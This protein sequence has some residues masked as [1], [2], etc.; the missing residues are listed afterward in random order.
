MVVRDSSRGTAT[1]APPRMLRRASAATSRYPAAG[2]MGRDCI[3]H[4]S[5]APAVCTDF[6]LNAVGCLTY[7][8]GQARSHEA[9]RLQQLS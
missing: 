5:G 1:G 4:A 3:A 2:K 6:K 8:V 9:P 7:L